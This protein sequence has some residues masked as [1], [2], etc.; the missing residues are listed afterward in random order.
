MKGSEIELIVS[1]SSLNSANDYFVIEA[2]TDGTHK[3]I[4][5]WGMTQWGTYASGIY[6]DGKF[7]DLASLGDGWY[8]VRWQDL[9][10]NTVPDYSTEFT[11]VASGA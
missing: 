9:N 1:W 2:I 10:A 11:V 8:I 6:F 3:V 4:I 5:L 7:T